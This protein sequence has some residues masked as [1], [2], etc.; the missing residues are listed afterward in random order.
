M[1]VVVMEVAGGFASDLTDRVGAVG[2]VRDC[3][4]DCLAE[5]GEA[6]GVVAAGEHDAGNVVAAR[7]LQDVVDGGDV[8]LADLGEGAL[9]AMAAR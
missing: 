1:I 9:V 6:D 7:S 5:W 8:V 4:G 3:V 2:G